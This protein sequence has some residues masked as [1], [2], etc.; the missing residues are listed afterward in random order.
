M[1]DVIDLIESGKIKRYFRV[2]GKPSYE[3]AI[4]HVTQHSVGKEPL[5][6]EE[7]DYLYMLH[8]IKDVSKRFKLN[9]YSF[10]LML[11]HLHLLLKLN[12]GNLSEAMQ[13]LFQSYATYFNKKYNR[14]GHVFSGAYRSALCFDE[15][16]LLAAS[17]YI[18]LNPVKA[19]LADRPADYRWSSCALYLN[20]IDIDTFID[21]KF[22]LTI[23]GDNISKA[24]IKYAGLLNQ[25]DVTEIEYA[26]EQPKALD[27][28]T[29]KLRGVLKD[30]YKGPDRKWAA[31]HGFLCNKDLEEEIKRLGQSERLRSP[32]ELEARKF[33]VEQLM[34]RGYRICDIANR[35]NLSR[36][37][38]YNILN[39]TK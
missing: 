26:S 7:P 20:E 8:L 1:A 25:I 30:F 11:N 37:T 9:I 23:L 10:A 4:T 17:L 6:L 31:E 12:A 16:Y 19:G 21:Y 18:H 36:R 14:K 2:R 3:G 38:I 15:V 13:G 22:I 5:F 32:K 24:I 33:L 35:L 29:E 39:F 27:F 34:A 28:I